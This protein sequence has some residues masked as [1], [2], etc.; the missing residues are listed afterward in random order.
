[1]RLMRSLLLLPAAALLLGA[2]RPVQEPAVTVVEIGAGLSMMIGQGG[3]VGVLAGPEG[4]FV[5][6]SQF[7]RMSTALFKAMDDIQ[8]GT[9]VRWLV[10]THWHGDHTG[11]NAKLG[12]LAFRMAHVKV[13][14]RMQTGTTS[15]PAAPPEALPNL[16]F[17]DGVTIYT[18]GQ[19]IEIRHVGPAHTDGDSILL[20]HGSKAAHAGDLLFNRMFPFVDHDSGGSVAGLI[21]ALKDLHAALPDDWRIIPGHG[22]LA[23]KADLAESIRMLESTLSL[24]KSR[25]EAK[26]TREQIFEAGLPEEWGTWSWSFVS[27]QRWMETLVRECELK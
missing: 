21:A 5:V 19:T 24:V 11:G 16:T 10:N 27:T 7:E 14:D 2:L 9:P 15:R 4:M 20:F 18:N 13:R 23:T 3:N 25:V 6:D 8:P 12:M 1:M 22:A 26:H 17:E